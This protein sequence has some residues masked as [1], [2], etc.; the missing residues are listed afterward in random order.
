MKTVARTL[1][2]A[3]AAVW[4]ALGLAIAAS[5]VLWP[6]AIPLNA[7]L[8][9]PFL[10][11]ALLLAWKARVLRRL[12]ADPVLAPLYRVETATYAAVL[13]VGAVLLTGAAHRLFL[14]RLPVFG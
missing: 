3:A 2:Q 4:L 7:A 6:G 14:E 5:G 12:P 8:A 11:V 10:A 13:L 1:T 9:A